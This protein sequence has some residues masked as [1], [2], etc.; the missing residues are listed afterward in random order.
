MIVGVSWGKVSRSEE[1]DSSRTELRLR[2]EVV[3]ILDVR[4]RCLFRPVSQ[5]QFLQR[6]FFF[7]FN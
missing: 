6:F 7:F 3:V 5:F 4:T 2:A 1:G